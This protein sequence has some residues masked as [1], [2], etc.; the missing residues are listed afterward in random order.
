IG[1]SVRSTMKTTDCSG[2]DA[3]F[4]KRYQTP[5]YPY[6]YE[7]DDENKKF[8]SDLNLLPADFDSLSEEEKQN[9][10]YTAISKV[11]RKLYGEMG[12]LVSMARKHFCL[13]RYVN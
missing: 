3:L 5:V 10:F 12:S 2:A 9:A 7:L 8:L 13:R 11:D 1:E 6:L 4:D